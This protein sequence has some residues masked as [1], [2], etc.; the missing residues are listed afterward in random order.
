MIRVEI[1]KHN[2]IIGEIFSRD[3]DMVRYPLICK[4]H[5]YQGKYYRYLFST[6]FLDTGYN[7]FFL[8]RTICD[9]FFLIFVDFLLS[10][11]GRLNF[12]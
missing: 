10:V 8:F 11:I 5:E 9:M 7:T 1:S 2:M 4:E 12:I 3:E 6:C